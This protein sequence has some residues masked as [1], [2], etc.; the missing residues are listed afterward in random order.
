MSIL[1]KL[2]F[3]LS[4]L[5]VLCRSDSSGFERCSNGEAGCFGIPEGCGSDAARCNAHAS[6]RPRD[7]TRLEVTLTGNITGSDYVALGISED[8]AMGDD[9]VFSCVAKDGSEPEV[10]T[11]VNRG[12]DGSEVVP[13]SEADVVGAEALARVEG[14]VLC[15]FHVLSERITVKKGKKDDDALEINLSEKDYYVMVAYGRYSNSKLMKHRDKGVSGEPLR[16]HSDRYGGVEGR[17][18]LLIQ[19]HGV[20]MVLAWG[21][22]AWTGMEFPL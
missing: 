7:Q 13:P 6:F 1:C 17:S 9:L 16:L 19:L 12:H 4:A 8:A 5:P 20:L 2:L 14:S 3:V 21:V 11:S 22:L 18:I 15:T 10:L